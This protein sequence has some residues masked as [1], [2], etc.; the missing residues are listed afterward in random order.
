MN[1]TNLRGIRTRSKTADVEVK[2]E[3]VSM[4]RRTAAAEVPTIAV[5]N[6]CAKPVDVRTC[7]RDARSV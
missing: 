1:T 5:A 3:G 4:Q 6:G 2:A 7:S